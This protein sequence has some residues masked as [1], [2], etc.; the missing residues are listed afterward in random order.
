[1]PWHGRRKSGCAKTSAGD[2]QRERISSCGAVAVGENLVQQRRA[3]DQAGFERAPFVR[4]DD[5][6]NRVELP[7]TLHA[8]R[9]AIDVVGDA[10]FVDEPLAGVRSGAAVPPRRIAPARRSASRNAGAA[11]RRRPS[12]SSNAAALAL[13]AGQQT[14]RRGAAF[15]RRW[16]RSSI[17]SGI[18]T[19]AADRGRCFVC[20][21]QTLRK[22]SVKGKSPFEFPAAA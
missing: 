19:F 18:E 7:R 13:V 9:V 6:R 14:G 20:P 4:R 16:L 10:L 2:S 8:A 5:E 12:N 15:R 22:S 11:R 21:R 1:M 3:L 17:G